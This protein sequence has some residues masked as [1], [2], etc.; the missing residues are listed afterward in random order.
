[1]EYNLFF[2]NRYEEKIRGI[3]GSDLWRLTSNKRIDAV[4]S[5]KILDVVIEILQ[6]IRIRPSQDTSHP[7]SLDLPSHRIVQ[8]TFPSFH[9]VFE[10]YLALQDAWGA[11]VLFFWYLD[12]KKEI[13]GNDSLF[14][15]IYKSVGQ[16]LVVMDPTQRKT[17]FD[18]AALSTNM[19]G[20]PFGSSFK[21]YIKNILTKVYPNPHRRNDFIE[22]EVA[23]L[24]SIIQD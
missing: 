11:G 7:Y 4:L 16:T 24:Q 3:L 9:R 14:V 17:T 5:R 20:E 23:F 8:E 15:D 6:K 22:T 18:F 10:P 13:Y 21:S 19:L 12:Q 1:V 2:T